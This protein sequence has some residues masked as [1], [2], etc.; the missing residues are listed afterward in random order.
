[1]MGVALLKW[2]KNDNNKIIQ[3]IYN[4]HIFDMG[5]YPKTL[6]DAYKLLES[7]SAAKSGG[8]EYSYRTRREREAARRRCERV[9]GRGRGRGGKPQANSF[10]FTKEEE[11]V[12]DTDGRGIATITCFR[13]LKKEHSADMCSSN[14]EEAAIHNIISE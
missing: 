9:G 5:V 6:Y 12:P 10:Q 2:D 8:K 14:A 4:Q 7:H 11:V 3:V 13:C 1:M